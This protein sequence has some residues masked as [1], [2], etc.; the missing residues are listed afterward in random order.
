VLVYSVHACVSIGDIDILRY[1][2]I[3]DDGA[4]SKERFPINDRAT[5]V[6]A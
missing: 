2:S 4:S 3:S 6:D 1:R 5:L